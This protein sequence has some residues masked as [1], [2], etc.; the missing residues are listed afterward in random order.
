MIPFRSPAAPRVVAIA[1]AL[2]HLPMTSGCIFVADALVGWEVRGKLVEASSR[3]P[4][5]NVS[6]EMKLMRS[7]QEICGAKTNADDQGEFR[8][9]AWI[10]IDCC[11]V[12]FPIPL[13]LDPPRARLGPPPDAIRILVKNTDGQTGSTT[14]PVERRATGITGWHWWVPTSGRIKLGTIEVSFKAVAEDQKNQ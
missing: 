7:E 13:P 5:G 11:L 1:L 9:L 4:L 10:D 14:V 6:V 12:V 8:A 3:E 2:L